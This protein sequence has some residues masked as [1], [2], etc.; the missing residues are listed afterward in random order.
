MNKTLP[1]P[2]VEHLYFIEV[3]VEQ[4]LSVGRF[5]DGSHRIIPITGGR[6]DGEKMKGTVRP[7]GADWNVGRGMLTQYSHVTTRYILVTDDGAVIS[8]FTDGRSEFGIDAMIG[9]MSRKPDPEKVKFRQHLFFKTGDERY[10]WLNDKVC[11]AVVCMN[12]DFK[13]CYDAYMVK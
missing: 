13:L 7:V 1:I 9:I 11:F 10:R 4:M 8:L 12:K 6:F 2:E 5:S 3:E